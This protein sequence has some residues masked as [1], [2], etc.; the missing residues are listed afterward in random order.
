[1]KT[2]FSP[3][4]REVKKLYAGAE[5]LKSPEHEN[6]DVVLVDI[7][8]GVFGVFDGLGG[9][10]GS[11]IAAGL[12]RDVV[13]VEL[14]ALPADA[15]FEAEQEAVRRALYAADRAIKEKERDR[16][17]R[18]CTTATVLKVWQN[19][20]G[21]RSLIIGNVGD[22]HAYYLDVDG[23]FSHITKDSD[24]LDQALGSS[25]HPISPHILTVDLVRMGDKILLC[26]DGVYVPL[27]EEM[28]KEILDSERSSEIAAQRL[29]T[30]GQEKA[31]E[32]TYTYGR[33]PDDASAV[34]IRL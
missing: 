7:E 27:T 9:Y 15:S 3:E 8:H 31:R 4:Q 24:N 14:A 16:L 23:N 17:G 28:L 26:S 18:M 20:G 2:E 33:A 5:S 30:M 29:A 13:R 11:E 34:V 22:S 6:Q 25:S 21:K 10:K 12:A 19:K 32:D 1:M